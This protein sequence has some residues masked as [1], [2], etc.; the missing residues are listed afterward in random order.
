MSQLRLSHGLDTGSE[1]LEHTRLSQ[2]VEAPG[3]R[4]AWVDINLG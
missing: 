1:N 3:N 2:E 4:Y